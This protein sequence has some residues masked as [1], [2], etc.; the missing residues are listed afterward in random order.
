MRGRTYARAGCA[1]LPLPLMRIVLR[2]GASPSPPV[3]A[4]R[5]AVPAKVH[6]AP[7]PVQYS[8]AVS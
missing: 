8:S 4:A 1:Y 6:G 7:A 2:I 3:C 5:P